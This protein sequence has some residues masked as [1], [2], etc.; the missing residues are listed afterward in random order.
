MSN[1]VTQ[2]YINGLQKYNAP[3]MGSSPF[4]QV[5]G[6]ALGGFASAMSNPLVAKLLAQKLKGW[7][8]PDQNSLIGNADNSVA[9]SFPVAPP[10][11]DTM[12]L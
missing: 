4:G 7:G 11:V 10:V 2:K 12:P 1:P 5:A 9:N 3:S 8:Q 6:G